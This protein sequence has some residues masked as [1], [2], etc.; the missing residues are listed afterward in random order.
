MTIRLPDKPSLTARWIVRAPKEVVE[1]ATLHLQGSGLAGIEKRSR[2]EPRLDPRQVVIPGLVNAHVHLDLTRLADTPLPR[3]PFVPWV[4]ALMRERAGWSDSNLSGSIRLGIQ[5][6]LAAGVTAV[7]DI[8]GSGEVGRA[9]DQHGPRGIAFRERVGFRPE[10]ANS[11]LSELEEGAWS[12]EHL[13]FGISPHAPYSCSAEL[14]RGV[15]QIARRLDCRWATHIAETHEELEFLRSGTGPLRDLLE[16]LDKLPGAWRP[17][18]ASPIEYLEGLGVLRSE[19]LLVH[20]NYLSDDDIGRI[21]AAGA[22]VV[23][24]PRSHAFFQHDAHPWPRLRA[25]GVPVALGTDSLGSND[26]LSVL[27]EM[28]FLV[29]DVGGCSPELAFELATIGGAAAMGRGDIGRL[30]VGG[31]ADL[32]ILQLADEID[33]PSDV[34]QALLDPGTRVCETWIGGQRVWSAQ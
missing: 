23:Y 33:R 26:S 16:S 17:P 20:A 14:Y 18:G 3:G 8:D 6:T 13:R 12:S 10:S 27:D 34:F 22:S 2:R 24:C 7:G 32:A 28:R 31:P 4:S 21:A 25:A 1:Q 30:R 5:S 29:A 9:Q 15:D 19:C 11:V